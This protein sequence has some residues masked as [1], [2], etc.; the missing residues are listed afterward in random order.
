MNTM[1]SHNSC[2]FPHLRAI[3]EKF[4]FAGTVGPEAP[5]VPQVA[6]PVESLRVQNVSEDLTNL[7]H[8][9]PGAQHADRNRTHLLWECAHG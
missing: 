2:T 9:Q 1:M 4:P 7:H 8:I 6:H 5:S 3:D